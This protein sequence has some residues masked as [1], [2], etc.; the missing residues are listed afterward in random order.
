MSLTFI[1]GPEKEMTG[2]IKVRTWL[3]Q[4][5]ATDTMQI[6]C[7]TLQDLVNIRHGRRNFIGYEKPKFGSLEEL[8]NVYLCNW[9][10]KQ[11][12]NIRTRP[13]VGGFNGGFASHR[14]AVQMCNDVWAA[15]HRYMRDIIRPQ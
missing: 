3:A 13:L 14:E 12:D 8:T 4:P 6:V 2:K 11:S 5:T 9:L 15:R 1:E 7:M 10:R